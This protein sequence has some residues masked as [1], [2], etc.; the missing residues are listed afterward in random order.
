MKNS[1]EKTIKP[2]NGLNGWNMSCSEWKAGS[3]V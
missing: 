2:D 3:A 1:Q